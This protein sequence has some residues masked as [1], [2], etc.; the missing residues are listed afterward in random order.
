MNTFY[1]LDF[2]F[3][4][5]K[6]HAG[7]SIFIEELAKAYPD[8]A[9][10]IERRVAES[11][12]TGV[13][14]A[15]RDATVELVGELETHA[16]ETQ[17]IARARSENLLFDGVHEVMDYIETSGTRFGI[18]TYGSVSGQ[19][20]KIHAAQ[21]QHVPFMVTD[22][23]KKGELIAGWWREDH[24][25]I[26]ES[27]GGGE[28]DEIVLVDDRLFSFEG[29]PDHAR[30]YWVQTGPARYDPVGDVPANVE[31]ADTLFE[32]IAAEKSRTLLT[33]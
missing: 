6:T 32:V 3:T 33:N 8:E 20:M 29:L 13:S 5:F 21:L 12:V 27:L 7:S 23:K 25:I 19:T 9:R 26:P 2:D 4:L 14:F 31:S 15:I 22:H 30:G 1:L 24:F 18:L 11:L 28:A 17:Y 16:I 10:E